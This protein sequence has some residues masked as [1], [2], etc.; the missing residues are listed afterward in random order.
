MVGMPPHYARTMLF[1]RER[2]VR[3]CHFLEIFASFDGY[4]ARWRPYKGVW[5]VFILPGPHK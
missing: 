3:L 5:N 4:I 2:D 1:R